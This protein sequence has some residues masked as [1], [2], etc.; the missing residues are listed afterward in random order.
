MCLEE[1]IYIHNIKDMK[2]LKTILEIPANP[3]GEL[4]GGARTPHL[5]A[6]GFL[7][8]LHVHLD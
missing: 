4:G 1:S 2:L 5:I 3:A 8:K 6:R 7:H